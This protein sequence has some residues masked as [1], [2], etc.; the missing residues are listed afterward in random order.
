[1]NREGV[2]R[3]TRGVIMREKTRKLGHM[4]TYPNW[5]VNGW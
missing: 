2:S 4:T 5:N 3:A 1:M